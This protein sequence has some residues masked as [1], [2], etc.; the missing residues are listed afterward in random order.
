MIRLSETSIRPDALAVEFAARAS[1]AGA[2]ASFTGIVRKENEREVAA[3]FLDHAGAITEREIERAA[4]HARSRWPLIE[5]A[6]VHRIG[7]VK[8]GEPVV[9]VATAAAHRRAAI[10]ACDF[11]VDFLKTDAPFWKK[12]ISRNGERW[13]EPTEKDYADRSR[14]G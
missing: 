8:A 14:W 7:S 12:E 13:I 2:I 6:I 5:L 9:F 11:L 3:L 4:A 1:G 10:E